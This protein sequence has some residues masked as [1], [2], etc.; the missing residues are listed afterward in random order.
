M[1]SKR[2]ALGALEKLIEDLSVVEKELYEAI[3]I[4]L[5]RIKKI[6]NNEQVSS[7]EIEGEK[8]KLNQLRA[9]D[10]W[11]RKLQKCIQYYFEGKTSLQE[12]LD[13][14]NSLNFGYL[15]NA[16]DRKGFK[17]AELLIRDM[18]DEIKT[19]WPDTHESNENQSKISNPWISG[20]FY[21]FALILLIILFL[22]VARSVSIF[23]LPIVLIAGFIAVS[24]IGA[25][26]LRQDKRLSEKSFLELVKLTF[27]QIPLLRDKNLNDKQLE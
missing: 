3:E 10:I 23:V 20:S 12:Y 7:D 14:S 17:R 25:F 18:I 8:Q 1:I 4:M 2:E 26:Q 24:L 5:P 15:Y 16:K 13:R 21:L 22:V 9:K 11:I 6:Q 27:Q 19:Y